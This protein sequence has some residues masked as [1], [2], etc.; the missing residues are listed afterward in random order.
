M[1]KASYSIR[2]ESTEFADP[3]LRNT[4]DKIMTR[5][6][7]T[8]LCHLVHNDRIS[9]Q[10]HPNHATNKTTNIKYTHFRQESDFLNLF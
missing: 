4:G 1:K 10:V 6:K 5:R 8:G 7:D 2:V 9:N 3:R